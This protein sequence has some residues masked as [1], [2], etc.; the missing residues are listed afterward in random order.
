MNGPLT[1][2]WKIHTILNNIK[3][4]GDVKKCGTV[5]NTGNKTTEHPH[6]PQIDR[7]IDNNTMFNHNPEHKNNINLNTTCVYLYS[8]IEK[9]Q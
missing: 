7:F 1:T 8:A 2:K 6:S 3:T 9:V 5:T 4:S